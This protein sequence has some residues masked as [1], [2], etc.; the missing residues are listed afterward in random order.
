MTEERAQPAIA[1]SLQAAYAE[2]TAVMGDRATSWEWG[3]IHEIQFR[4]PLLH[5][6]GEAL[7]EKMRYPTYPRGGSGFTTNNTGF[8]AQDMLVRGGASYRQVLDVG[9]WDAATMTNAPGQSGDPRSPFYDNLLQGWAEDGAF[10]L[11][12]SREKVLAHQALTIRL[13]PK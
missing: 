3:Y 2:A 8:S 7:A 12:F 1:D 10:P 5:L 9:N 11:I 13:R 4:H 6:A